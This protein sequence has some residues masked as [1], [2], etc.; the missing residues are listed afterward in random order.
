M[1]GVNWNVKSGGVAM[2]ESI[3]RAIW[4]L[5]GWPW[6]DNFMIALSWLG[7]NGLVWCVLAV[8][9]LARA[10]TR[11]AGLLCALALLLSLILCN[12]LLKNLVAR[13]RPY[14]TL[15]WLRPLVPPLPDF[16]FPSGH[17]CASC[18]AA[19]AL[20]WSGLSKKWAIPAFAL[21]LLISFSRLYV[22]VH[23]PSDVLGGLLLGLLCGYVAWRVDTRYNLEQRFNTG[24][25]K[26]RPRPYNNKCNKSCQNKE[27]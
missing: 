24:I 20:A 19:A 5:S 7:N 21:A 25:A 11:R 15:P 26:R 16:S 22:G 13:P 27:E 18:A 1:F 9:F 12:L 23:Y 14:E 2:D 10:P 6:L 17:A 3:L 4:Q 8:L